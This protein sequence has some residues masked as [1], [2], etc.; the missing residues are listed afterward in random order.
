[1][2]HS[3]HCTQLFFWNQRTITGGHRSAQELTSITLRHTDF[4][5]LWQT[6]AWWGGLWAVFSLSSPSDMSENN[7]E[8]AGVF[9][10]HYKE[11]VGDQYAATAPMVWL[12]WSHR[13]CYISGVWRCW[14]AWHVDRDAVYSMLGPQ[15]CSPRTCFLRTQVKTT[16]LPC[17]SGIF[18]MF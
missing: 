11:R 17:H 18:L 9:D 4:Y 16:R 7:S 12:K 14:A 15:Q 2:L 13:A 1:M 8:L 10:L 3:K 6:S 5:L